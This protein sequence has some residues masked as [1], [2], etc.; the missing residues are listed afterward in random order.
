MGPILLLK[1]ITSCPFDFKEMEM[2]IIVAERAAGG[3]NSQETI[4]YFDGGGKCH[5]IK[6]L[7]KARNFFHWLEKRLSFWGFPKKRV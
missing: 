4:T 1:N 2:V 6:D 5:K 7:R 3:Y